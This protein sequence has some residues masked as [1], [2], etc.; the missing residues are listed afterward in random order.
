M[1]LLP[2]D[3]GPVAGGPA[4]PHAHLRRRSPGD[5]DCYSASAVG[6]LEPIDRTALPYPMQA[7]QNPP[8]T[9]AITNRIS[10]IESGSNIGFPY[11]SFEA[12]RLGSSYC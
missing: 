4:R 2:Q 1:V 3:A 12:V 9:K 10:A 8:E 5:H 7:N 6:E 11:Q